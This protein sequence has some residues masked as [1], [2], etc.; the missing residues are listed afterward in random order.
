VEQSLAIELVSHLLTELQGFRF[1]CFFTLLIAMQQQRAS[2][3]WRELCP[4]ITLSKAAIEKL[5]CFTLLLDTI[6]THNLLTACYAKFSL[7]VLCNPWSNDWQWWWKQLDNHDYSNAQTRLKWVKAFVKPL[8]LVSWSFLEKW[9]WESMLAPAFFLTRSSEEQ[10]DTLQLRG[11]IMMHV[12]WT[13]SLVSSFLRL[14]DA[15]LWWCVGLEVW[16]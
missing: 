10:E 14:R 15:S 1:K 6:T 11:A 16:V 4:L 12:T 8:W 2:A 7:E 3:T 9:S 13:L 5:D